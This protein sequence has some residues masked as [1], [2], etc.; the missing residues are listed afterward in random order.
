MPLFILK[1]T[2]YE[3]WPWWFFYIPILPY[4]LWLAIKTKSL[5]FFTATNT[6][7]E[8]GGFFGESKIDILNQIPSKYC[9]KTI[10][11]KQNT[12]IDVVLQNE[13]QFPIILKPNIGERG[14]NVE[15]ISDELSLKKYNA[16]V[17]V[18]YILQEF[19]EFPIELGVLFYRMPNDEKGFVT[20]IAIKEFLTVLG[21][22]KSSILTLMNNSTRARFQIESM[23]K[24]MG[25]NINM[26]VPK[27]EKLLLEPIGNHCRGTRFINGNHLINEKLHL[28]FN[29]I[30]RDMKG[31]HYGRFDLKVKSI[32]DLYNGKNI[33]I[34]ELN[35]ASSEPG[36]IYDASYGLK[37][38]YKNLMFHWNILAKIAIQN[39]AY[40]VKP[41][42]FALVVKTFYQHFFG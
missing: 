32:D 15:K 41:V 40:G 27:D 20:S 9:P 3:Y 26:I 14:F 4:W 36:H 39:K 2:N 13:I 25:D 10:Y 33:R 37:N 21:D 1:W 42:S 11:I 38:A 18:D 23:K 17:N 16:E 34:M 5:A 7:I 30:A 22:G 31:F 19:I 6:N 28:V 35:G 29:K 8:M 24:K 12:P